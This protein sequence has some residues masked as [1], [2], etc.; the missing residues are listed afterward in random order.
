MG[1]PFNGQPN[2]NSQLPPNAKPPMDPMMIV[3]MMMMQDGDSSG[4]MMLPMMMMMMGGGGEAGGDMMMPM[5]M[6]M[7][8]KKCE[9][10]DD[11]EVRD[12]ASL[13]C[14]EDVSDIDE[15]SLE[16]PVTVQQAES[17]LQCALSQVDDG[18]VIKRLCEVVCARSGTSSEVCQDCK[19]QL[20]SI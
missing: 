9:K 5:M 12:E 1:P 19:N 2:S 8:G 13:N 15:C 3:M 11:C 6:M 20:N 18:C 10:C 7:S 16:F 17:Y 14:F 4:D